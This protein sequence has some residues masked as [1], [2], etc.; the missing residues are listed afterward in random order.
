MDPFVSYNENEV[1]WIWTLAFTKRLTNFLRLN[2]PLQLTNFELT[3]DLAYYMVINDIKSFQTFSQIEF[4][5]K[6]SDDYI[7][8]HLMKDV[9]CLSLFQVLQSRVF[10]WPYPQT[11]DYAGKACCGPTLKLIM[12]IRKLWPQKVL[13]SP[14]HTN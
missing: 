13:L 10:S 1:L 2:R 6:M 4:F 3:N 11:L 14:V 12:N 9:P 5:P 7:E 8:I